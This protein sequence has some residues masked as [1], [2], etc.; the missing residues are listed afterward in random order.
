MVDLQR[1]SDARDR[2]RE[3]GGADL[4]ARERRIMAPAR[5]ISARGWNILLRVYRGIADDR[6]LANAAAVT[7]FALLA[8][9][10][11]TAA[12]VSIYGLLADPA[13]IA[14]QLDAISGILPGGAIEV[15]RDQLTRLTNRPAET[16]GVGFLIGLAAALW[17]ANGG[18]KAL[19]DALNTVYEEREERS[20]VAFNALS[21]AFTVAMMLF[22]IVAIACVVAIPVALNYLP[23]FIGMVL[24]FA[25]WPVIAVIVT[26]VLACLYHYGPSQTKARW[27]WISWGSVVAAFLW[28]GVSALF[29]FYAANFGSFNKTYG[30][31]GAVIGFMLWIWLSV[32]VILLGGKLNA[33]IERQTTRDST[34][35]RP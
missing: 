30:S 9:F 35:S 34:T 4:L 12:L 16:L 23:G 10:P 14:K 22:L 11:A 1:I 25:R 26:V 31:L 2:G 33:E 28:L 29:S 7:F 18:I 13:S 27:R 15:I 32:I 21:L 6:I 24:N 5:D 3:G 19:F 8:L 17:S 20:F